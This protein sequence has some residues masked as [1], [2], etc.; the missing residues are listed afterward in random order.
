MHGEG[1]VALE[2]MSVVTIQSVLVSDE[3]ECSTG[4]HDCACAALGNCT[5]N[6]LNIDGSYE[7]YCSAGYSVDPADGLTC[8]S[9]SLCSQIQSL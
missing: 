8:I 4:T 2:Y 1:I 7:C 3:D 5:A 6:C 9:E